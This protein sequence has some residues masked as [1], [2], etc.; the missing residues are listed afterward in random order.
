MAE[1]DDLGDLR[2]AGDMSAHGIAALAL[3]E[4]YAMTHDKQLIVPAQLAVRFSER[5]QNRTTGGWGLQPQERDD[6]HIAG[7]QWL[8]LRSAKFGT[9]L[10]AN[11]PQARSQR[12][13]N[14]QQAAN[15]KHYYGRYMPGYDVQATAIGLVGRVAVNDTS[16]DA[17]WHEAAQWAAATGPAPHDVERNFWVTQVARQTGG[18]TWRR[19]SDQLRTLIVKRQAGDGPERGSWF[20]AEDLAAD[21]GRIYQTALNTMCLEVY[22]RHLPVYRDFLLKPVA[23]DKPL[24]DPF[25]APQPAPAVGEEIEDPF[26]EPADDDPFGG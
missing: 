18:E 19:W 9:L 17:K 14:A 10:V 22:Y 15:G 12:Y 4:A 5:S 1:S 8:V 3:T 21:K 11:E 13:L 23:K 2:G 25:A 20:D 16:D 7:W 6:L 26:G 24:D